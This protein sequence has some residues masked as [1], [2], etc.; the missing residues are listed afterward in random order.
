[1]FN[2]FKNKNKEKG[3]TKEIFAKSH[4]FKTVEY[5]NEKTKVSFCLTFL[6]TLV[7]EK[8]IRECALPNLLEKEFHKLEDTKQILPFSDIQFS[9]DPSKVEEK[10]L[11]GTVLSLEQQGLKRV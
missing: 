7:E 10:L 6:S 4:D 8:N 2:L 1:M 5:T 9:S 11:S 3:S